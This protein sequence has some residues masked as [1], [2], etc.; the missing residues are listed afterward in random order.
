MENENK[1]IDIYVKFS[2]QMGRLPIFLPT[3]ERKARQEIF[4]CPWGAVKITG[5]SLTTFDEDVLY[6]LCQVGERSYVYLPEIGQINT[7]HFK[8][9]YYDLYKA[10]GRK[11]GTSTVEQLK[12]SLEALSTTHVGFVTTVYDPDEKKK[13]DRKKTIS[14]SKPLIY[15]Y[16]TYDEKDKE[17][18]Y[19]LE[20]GQ[21]YVVISEAVSNLL[22]FS[23][24]SI[25]LSVKKQLP[26]LLQALYRF[27]LSHRDDIPITLKKLHQAI[28]PNMKYREFKYLLG[29]E[30]QKQ[31]LYEKT[32]IMYIFAA[33]DSVAIMK[34]LT[35]EQKKLLPT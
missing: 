26:P 27:A 10:M 13:K 34:P 29:K 25:N 35:R 6:T 16:A 20:K 24:T 17:N 8:G 14:S 32:G 9:T 15:E 31:L 12:A 19:K 22:L 33:N 30:D 23:K 11:F 2:Q 28:A 7:I 4:E 1:D 18:R 3:N 21:F 5:I